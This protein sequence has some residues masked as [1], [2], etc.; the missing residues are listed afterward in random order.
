MSLAEELG[1]EVQEWHSAA[2]TTW[3]ELMYQVCVLHM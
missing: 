2:P 1:Y 3:G